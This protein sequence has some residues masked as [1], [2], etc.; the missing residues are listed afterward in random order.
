MKWLPPPIVKSTGSLLKWR[1]T[2]KSQSRTWTRMLTSLTNCK[3]Q[4]NFSKNF[5]K[6]RRSSKIWSQCL[7]NTEL[8]MTMLTKTKPRS[9]TCRARLMLLL[10]S[11]QAWKFSLRRLKKLPSRIEMKTWPLWLKSSV[12]SKRR[13]LSTS[14]KSKARLWCPRL[15]LTRRLLLSLHVC[16]Q[17]SKQ[18]CQ[19]SMSSETLKKLWKPILT[20]SKKFKNL[21]LNTIAGSKSG[22]TGQNL[23]T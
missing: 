17:S 8:K 11:S 6:R 18:L 2:W 12:M 1:K 19:R 10:T 22:T 3:P 16:K 9:Q 14:A 5:A 20:K 13:L 21:K 23:L 15:L 7:V 4:R